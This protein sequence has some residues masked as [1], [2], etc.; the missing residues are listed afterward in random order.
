M[1]QRYVR[2]RHELDLP[3][4]MSEEDRR[5]PC[6]DLERDFYDYDDYDYRYYDEREWA[7]HDH[8]ARLGLVFTRL[9]FAIQN[10]E[11]FNPVLAP[12]LHLY[13]CPSDSVRSPVDELERRVVE[14]LLG[15]DED[16]VEDMFEPGEL[17]CLARLLDGPLAEVPDLAP[18]LALLRPF[19]LRDVA[20]WTPGSPTDLIEHLLVA[21]PYP[22][23]LL[24]TWIS[25]SRERSWPARARAYA[26]GMFEPRW[27]AWM[28]V[29]CQGGSLRRLEKLAS[30]LGFPDTWTELPKRLPGL[31]FDV[32][33]K[34]DPGDGLIY[35]NM[36]L[37][38]GSEVEFRRLRQNSLAVFDTADPDPERLE[39][40]QA[41]V[42][43]FA[44]HREELRD[45]ECPRLLG[46]VEHVWYEQRRVGGPAFRWSG[47]TLAA[48]R[49]AVDAHYE[50]LQ[51]LA[52]IRRQAHALSWRSLGIDATLEIDGERWQFTELLDGGSLLR[53]TQ[54][55]H[56]CV[57]GYAFSCWQRRC[58]I[59]S[60]T[61]AG[62]PCLTIELSLPQREA[63]QIR[64][65]CNRM[66]TSEELEVIASWRAMLEP[67]ASRSQPARTA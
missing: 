41:T 22:R 52:Q 23:F 42:R 51:R 6:Q 43:W 39:H 40:W 32:P 18:A 7:R 58:A 31:L 8:E 29:A 34:L 67:V 10:S 20:A 54:R 25:P 63:V 48:V 35:A 44:H 26:N 66:P 36:L 4:R 57:H 21:Y 24:N 55:M 61:R 5:D 28:L 30:E 53:E 64:G 56:H 15:V 9:R 50:D 17:A 11:T 65:K 47:R 45:D 46:W 14:H 37:V 60:V 2:L 38:G 27:I 33:A 49:R 3:S 12:R 62:A 1:S 19:W 13:R 59:V 16:H